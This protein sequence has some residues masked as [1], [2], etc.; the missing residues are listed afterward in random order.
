MATRFFPPLAG[1]LLLLTACGSVE[2][3]PPDADSTPVDAAPDAGMDAALPDA[4]DTPANVTLTLVSSGTG[5]G[6][7]TSDPAGITCGAV[8]QGT[9]P[10]GTT[11]TLTAAAGASSTFSGWGGACAGTLDTCSITLVENT[12]VNAGFAQV[13]HTV[14]LTTSG[15][16]AGS[17]TSN[18]AGITCPG[19]CTTTVPAGTQL[20]LTAAPTPPSTFVGWSGG[21]CNGTAGCTITVGGD[22]AIGAAFALDYTLVVQ[23]QGTGAGTVT[24][25][26]AGINCGADCN[27]TYAANTVVSLTASP[28]AGSTFAGWGGACNGTGA[29]S[30]TL[31]TAKSVTATF[32][33]PVYTLTVTHAG[34]GGG[35]TIS[36]PAGINCTADC[37]ESYVSGTMV[38][39]NAGA[40]VGSTFNGF[41]GACAGSSPCTVTMS[42]ARSVTATF[43]KNAP[44]IAFVTSTSHNGNLGGLA[45]ADAICKAR[46]SAAGLAGSYRAWLSTSTT[47]AIT[48]LGSA[49][50]WVR[51]DGKPLVDS[52]SDL[53]TGKLIHPLRYDETGTDVGHVRVTT[54][55]KPDGTVATSELCSNWTSA[56]GTTYTTQGSSAGLAGMFTTIGGQLCSSAAR[57]YCF[58]VDRTAV[59]D[60]TPAASYR[61]AFTTT[62]AFTPS[63]GL[64][65]ADALCAQEAS[66]ASLPGTYKALLATSTASAASRFSTTGAHWGRLDGTVLA[67][68]TSSTFQGTRWNVTPNLS[69]DKTEWFGNNGV[70]IGA[71]SL[72]DKGTAATTC[73]NWTSTSSTATAAGGRIGYTTFAELANDVISSGCNSSVRKL[74]C[75]QE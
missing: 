28:S 42:Q 62:S 72:V 74:I 56:T 14:T 23:K 55:T 13:T 26:P 20:T 34:T 11:V 41:S 47:N 64:A 44:N 22:V 7:I 24:S 9:F 69:A 3:S 61:R 54:G 45:G 1:A 49:R 52:L 19:T 31:D 18:P 70:W 51:T 32:N 73:N 37:S 57:L 50:G 59:V 48:R 29:C 58:G 12:A 6:T 38:T 21:S 25:T 53:T 27:E 67:L 66:A 65:A 8:C 17:V 75:M 71:T 46:A 68:L 39:L 4:P 33:L 10:V 5:T 36:S 35:R 63:G 43:T 60:V 40:A 30:V 2:D 16:G 15:N